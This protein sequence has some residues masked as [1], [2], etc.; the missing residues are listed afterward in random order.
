[1]R[2]PELLERDARAELAIADGERLACAE[3]RRQIER[4]ERQLSRLLSETFPRTS[5]PAAIGR[6]PARFPR[7]LD[8][9]GLEAVRDELAAR[10]AEARGEIRRREQLEAENR[11]V[12]EQML[13]DPARFR[14]VRIDRADVGERGCGAW[15]S[16]PKLGLIGMLMGWW[17]VRISSGCP[18]AARLAAADPDGIER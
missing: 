11:E 4:L 2:M 1:M 18:L 3:L 6:P 9:G 13:A 7:A 16:R 8:L 17:R 12:L 15:H 14:W 10:V 5:V